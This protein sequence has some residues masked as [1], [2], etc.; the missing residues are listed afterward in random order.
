M[1]ESVE[2]TNRLPVLQEWGTPL[3]RVDR[4][5]CS[6]WSAPETHGEERMERNMASSTGGEEG[7]GREHIITLDLA[8]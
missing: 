2:G 7:H 5:R 4:G 6:R 8:L 3:T 1:K